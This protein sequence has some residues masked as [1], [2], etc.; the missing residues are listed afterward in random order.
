MKKN[1]QKIAAASLAVVMA[2][3][4]IGYAAFTNSETQVNADVKSENEAE[5]TIKQTIENS[6][7]IST[8]G[9][10]KEETVYVISDANGNVTKTIV[11]DWLKNKDGS[12]TL[13]DRTDLQDIENVKTDADYMTGNNNEIIW[14]AKG[15]DVYYQGTSDKMLPVDVKLTYYLDGKEISPKELAGQSGKVK[16]RFDYIANSKQEVKINDKNVELYVPFTMISGFLLSNDNFS[17]IEVTNGKVINDGDRSIVLGIGFAGLGEDL[18]LSSV[19]KD[20]Q[21]QIPN[22]VEVTADVKDFSL[23]MTLTFGTA[24]LLNAVNVDDTNTMQDLEKKID[25]LISA[26]NQLK[27]GSNQ[28]KSGAAELKTSFVTYANG[29]RQ[30]GDGIYALDSGASQLEEKSKEF[31]SG[32]DIALNGTNQILSALSGESGAAAGAKKLS[33]GANHLAAGIGTTEDIKNQNDKTVAGAVSAIDSA[34]GQLTGGS[35]TLAEAIGSSDYEEVLK[36]AA[37]KVPQ[38]IAGAVLMVAKGSADL[39]QGLAQILTGFNDVTDKDGNVIQLGLV[40]GLKAVTKALGGTNSNTISKDAASGNPKTLQGGAVAIDSGMGQLQ[41]GVSEMAVNIEKSI[42]DNKN[43]MTQIETALAYIKQSGIDPATGTA[44]TA[45]AIEAY[46]TNYAALSGANTALQSVIN[47]MAAANLDENIQ[48][49]KEGTESLKT[50]TAELAEAVSQLS[51]GA[52]KLKN[53]VQTAKNGSSQLA[54]GSGTLNT[55]MTQATKGAEELNKNLGILSTG[56]NKLNSQM[57]TLISGSS[58]LATGA[59]ALSDGV[60][61][62]YVAVSVQLQPGLQQLYDGGILLGSS[63][64]TLYSGT[65]TA[66]SGTSEIINGTSKLSDGINKLADGSQTLSDGIGKFKEEGIDKITN[67]LNGDIKTVTDR[68][69]A[70]IDV[71]KNYSIYTMSGENKTASVKFIYRTDEISK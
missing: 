39:D 44:A 32:L 5:S 23:L 42:L 50:G 25:E 20:L 43:K 10:D 1:I 12:E 71:A 9:V 64:E 53:G 63:L 62:L 35:K 40:N 8:E 46:K 59:K 4:G 51:D 41:D 16:I 66:V 2:V 48:A 15:E 22:Y 60:Q 49:L 17:N 37:Q 24:D 61:T 36:D 19:L 21:L 30:L 47:Q 11:S 31:V 68:I 38:T 33:E 13:S 57:G 56:T 70:T 55:N 52:S 18:D 69:K 14:N 67:A 27:D 6:I 28:L 34:A 45:E 54:A 29:I 65:Q 3:S 58:E 26:A 7:S